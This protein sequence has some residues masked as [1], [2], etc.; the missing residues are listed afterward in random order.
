MQNIHFYSIFL[1]LGKHFY[2]LMFKYFVIFFWIFI[3]SPLK[4]QWKI[5]WVFFY[6][7]IQNKKKN[8]INAGISKIIFMNKFMLMFFN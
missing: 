2:E 3:S 7:I 1:Q 8:T 4:L 5:Y 6:I